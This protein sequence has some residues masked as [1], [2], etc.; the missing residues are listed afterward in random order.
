MQKG[1][2]KNQAPIDGDENQSAGPRE[3]EE[4]TQ[5]MNEELDEDQAQRQVRNGK[6]QRYHCVT[7]CYWQTNRYRPG[8]IQDFKGEPP[9]SFPKQH[10]ERE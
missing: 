8:D 1:S 10:F 7:D 5:P 3:G 6:I 2:K 9:A 4:E